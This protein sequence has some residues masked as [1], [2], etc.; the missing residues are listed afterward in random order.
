[1]NC[2][3][4]NL[5]VYLFFLP[6]ISCQP[7]AANSKITST[8]TEEKIEAPTKSK[9]N[10]LSDRI[11]T[12]QGFKRL[13]ISES[14]YAHYLRTIPLKPEGSKAK[15]YN[16]DIKPSEGIYTAVIDLDIGQE[17]LHQCADAIMR[18]KAEYLWQS[19]QYDKI[20]FNFTN[21][22][23]VDYSEWMKGRRMIVEGNK[24]YWDNQ[25]NPSNTYEDFWQYMELIFMYAGTASLEKELISVP[26]SQMK[27]GD[28]LIKGGFPGHAVVI[29]DMAIN[30]STG[31]KIFL[32]AQSYMPAQ[33]AQILINR[34]NSE[35]SPWY[36]LLPSKDVTSPQWDFNPDQLRRFKD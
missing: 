11:E 9:T 20:H 21:G 16:G 28:V 26:L 32:M 33:E 34:E 6:I 7:P 30:E 10:K 8:P 13:P 23:R 31:Q 24:T 12:P 14:S 1:M 36:E 19:K 25:S 35:L 15:Y 29:M 4:K 2:F 3:I 18:L 27:I 5:L 22:F 17:D